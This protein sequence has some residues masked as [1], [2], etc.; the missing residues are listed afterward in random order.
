M[1]SDLIAMSPQELRRLEAMHQLEARVATQGE[2]ALRLQLST[3]QVKRL[4]RTYRSN[5]E[6]G[7]VSAKR[8]RP[9]NRRRDPADIERAIA[10]VREHYADF[11]PTFASEK[12]A[13]QHQLAVDRETLRKAMIAA[14]LWRAK[15]R[16]AAYHPPRERRPCFGELVQIDGS[17]HAW[18]EDR[19]PKCTLLV[20]IDD[21]TSALV[22]LRFAH[23]ETTA[24]YFAL[25]RIYFAQY[26]LPQ[27]FYSD[28]F[29]IFRI[30][31][32]SSPTNDQ[33]QFG[34]AL[35]QLD[36]AL[37]CANSPQAKGRVERVNRTL[38]DRLIK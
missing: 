8:G 26:G 21:A 14:G 35:D 15:P 31:V 23:N 20:F 2:V 17:P 29:G 24:E 10:L 38:Q 30:N 37:I 16:K 19:G 28:R 6:R 1:R 4:W 5:G 18:F 13:E 11:G 9:G 3:R 25:A 7:L 22:G 34:R 33:T 32:A 36:I 27:A 12:L